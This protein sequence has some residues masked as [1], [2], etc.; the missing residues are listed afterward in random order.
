MPISKGIDIHEISQEVHTEKENW[1]PE[2]EL[3]DLT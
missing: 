1:Q 2:V 3:P